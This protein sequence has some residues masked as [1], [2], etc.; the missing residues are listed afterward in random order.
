[1]TWE[2]CPPHSAQ[3]LRLIL[4]V[5]YYPFAASDRSEEVTESAESAHRYGLK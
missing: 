5:D 4:P 1:M 3:A 2:R